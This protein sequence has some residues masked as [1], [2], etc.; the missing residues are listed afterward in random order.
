MDAMYIML[1]EI[2]EQPG[3]T[4]MMLPTPVFGGSIS[5]FLVS[6]FAATS[7]LTREFRTYIDIFM[8]RRNRGKRIKAIG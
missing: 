5:V 1:K 3:V 2:V 4:P 8:P 6:L 7:S